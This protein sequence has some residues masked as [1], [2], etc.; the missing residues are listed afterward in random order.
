[1]KV[2]TIDKAKFDKVVRILEMLA[3]MCRNQ[4]DRK[5]EWL[6]YS[7]LAGCFQ[8][9]Q[10]AREEERLVV[11]HTIFVPTELLYAMDIIPMYL[12]GTGE[13]MARMLD[14]E[15]SFAVAKTAGFAGE[16]C[17]GHRLLNAMTY[18]GWLPRADAFIW[19]NLVC[20]LTAKTGDYLTQTYD[21]PGLYLD[22]PYH[23]TPED[24]RY[25]KRE[26]EGMICFLED[27][28][29]RKMDYDRLSEVMENTRRSTL[30]FRE[31]CELRKSVPSPMRSHHLI[32]MTLAQLLL[33]GAPELVNFYEVIRDEMKA[34]MQKPVRPAENYRL[35]NFF[36]YPG[37]L[38]KFLNTMETEYHASM[39]AEPHLSLWAEAEIDPSRP[40]E[41][42]ADKAFAL[43]DTGPLKGV[44]DR[45]VRQ[46]LEYKAEGAIYWAHLGCRQTCATIKIIKDALAGIDVPMLVVDCDMADATVV[47]EEEITD[48]VEQF[49]ELL[50]DR[51]DQ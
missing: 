22:R 2:T 32:E 48:R 9:V 19:S 20:D 10:K 51:R 39:V 35:M 11:G 21:R 23:D 15:D 27:L 37:Y 50:D 36:F 34:E 1:M 5:G 33:S 46:A 6:Y 28:S 3:R 30:V 17:S 25:Y 8:K 13:I 16:I 26:L 45:M 47:S 31:I 24:R 44:A 18:Q 7:L 40:L 38:W 12:E 49:L 42:L 29:H 4:S 41:S 43:T 14:L